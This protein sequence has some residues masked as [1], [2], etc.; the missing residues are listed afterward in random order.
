MSGISTTK[1]NFVEI[2]LR[3]SFLHMRDFAPLGTVTRYFLGRGVLEKG[4]TAE[5]RINIT[6]TNHY[7]LSLIDPRDRLRL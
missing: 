3:V 6:S 1:Q 2:G 7:Q 5:T 4:A